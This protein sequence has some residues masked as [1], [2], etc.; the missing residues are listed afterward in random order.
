[1]GMNDA[2]MA[3]GLLPGILLLLGILL[4][5]LVAQLRAS[6][7]ES[8]LLRENAR[9]EARLAAAGEQAADRGRLVDD[10]EQRLAALTGRL[11]QEALHRN[12]EAFLDLAAQRLGHQ[13]ELA[14]SVLA[15]REQAVAALVT[16]ISAALEQTRQQLR[17]MEQMRAES[18]GGIRAQMESMQ[19]A[20]RSLQQET[21]NLATALRR[22]EVRGRWGEVTLRRIAEL[23]GMV[24]HCDFSEQ[25]S[26]A[27]G[28]QRPDLLVHLPRGGL[29]VIDVKTPLDAYLESIEA[30]DPE[31][32]KL[33]L[34]RHTRNLQQRVRELAAKAY[35]ASLPQSPEMV[36][37]FVPGEQFLAAA[38]DQNPAL[39]EHAMAQK[40]VLTTPSSLMALLTTVAHG[41]RQ[42]ALAE[43]AEQIRTLGEELY[44]RLATFCAHLGRLGRQL[45]GSVNAY[46]QSVGSL[47]RMVLPGARKLAELGVRG[48]QPVETPAPIESTPRSPAVQG[49]DTYDEQGSA[50]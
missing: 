35:W 5:A 32:R 24:E 30:V 11:A 45:E 10:V 3:A 8:E 14:A 23:A 4:G 46:N 16:P 9:L 39:L 43:N 17:E 37:L 33:A 50:R 38:L 15:Q 28:S 47:E 26:T 2:A 49:P 34:Q 48:N 19:A 27:D 42:L 1:M 6:R 12:S 44:S 7:R 40:V 29:L 41:W 13:Q 36:I 22:P 18:F 20:Q 31:A 21:R 25:A